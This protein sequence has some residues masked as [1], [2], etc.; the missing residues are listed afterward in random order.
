LAGGGVKPFVQA[1]TADLG[2]AEI[3]RIPAPVV[4]RAVGKAPSDVGDVLQVEIVKNDRLSVAG[5]NDILLQKVSAHGVRHGLSLQGV[6]GKVCGGAAVGDD[7]GDSSRVRRGIG[8]GSCGRCHRD[9]H[10][11]ESTEYSAQHRAS[12]QR[13]DGPAGDA[14][15]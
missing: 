15:P 11:Q 8:Q 7:D 1:Q 13:Q 9:G 4:T 6:L 12:L 10:R 3:D 5:E 14:A 2:Q